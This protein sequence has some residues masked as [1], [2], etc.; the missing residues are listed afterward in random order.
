M[1]DSDPLQAIKEL[2][3]KIGLVL[4]WSTVQDDLRCIGKLFRQ[5]IWVPQ[6]KETELDQRHT[7]WE[8]SLSRYEADPFV[9]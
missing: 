1:A 3:W 2:S 4:P 9:R 5:R 6:V 8:S 7:I